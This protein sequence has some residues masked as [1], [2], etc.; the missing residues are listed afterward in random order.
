MFF[1]FIVEL[2]DFSPLNVTFTY[3]GTNVT[4]LSMFQV[5]QDTII[6]GDEFFNISI[7]PGD[8]YHIGNM[9]TASVRIID[10]DGKCTCWILLWLCTE[11]QQQDCLIHKIN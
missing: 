3:D 7:V 4:A 10:D 8:G 11:S 2:I 6:E 9:S 1:I 5:L